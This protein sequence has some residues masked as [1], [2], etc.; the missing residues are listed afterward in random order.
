MSKI[1]LLFVRKFAN[2]QLFA[3]FPASIRKNLAYFSFAHVSCKGLKVVF[4][5]PIK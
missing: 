1:L 5:I 2:S 4:T 3:A